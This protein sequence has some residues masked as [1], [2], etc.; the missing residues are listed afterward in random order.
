MKK[1]KIILSILL[2]ILIISTIGLTVFAQETEDLSKRVKMTGFC[3]TDDEGNETNNLVAG[4]TIYASCELKR[5]DV[6]VG[7]QKYVFASFV[8]NNNKL[9]D[10]IKSEGE[11]A[12]NDAVIP[13]LLKNKIILPDELTNAKVKT[14]LIEDMID[15]TPLASPADFGSESNEILEI[16]AN[17]TLLSFDD[18]QD[19]YIYTIPLLKKYYPIKFEAIVKNA[20]S[21]ID[22]TN[23]SG[24]LGTANIKVT[25]HSGL[26]SSLY[27]IEVLSSGI[28]DGVAKKFGKKAYVNTG[29]ITATDFPTTSLFYLS[30]TTGAFGSCQVGFLE[31]ELP[32]VPYDANYTATLELYT[33]SNKEEHKLQFFLC[34]DENWSVNEYGKNV[35]PAFDDTKPLS[36]TMAVC[37]VSTTGAY[38][39]C[40]IP[41]KNELLK[42]KSKIIIAVR[43][44]FGTLN[45]YA[46]INL[47]DHQPVIKYK[48]NQ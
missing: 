3:Y 15:F 46:Y 13:A 7:S 40:E 45:G 24:Y 5:T 14:L 11:V 16:Y 4:E 32:D 17:D 20:A 38:T 19:A 6:G 47:K 21:K 1:K 36:D 30:R 18:T 42:G 27:N 25:S 22:I 43:P 28:P 37:P 2:V 44:E 41:L 34:T 23:L 39:K 35:M 8:Y 9:V 29:K 31:F 26:K 48:V 10:V 12:T 33:Y